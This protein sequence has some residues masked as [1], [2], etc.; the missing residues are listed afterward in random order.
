M[1]VLVVVDGVGDLLAG[2]GQGLVDLPGGRSDGGRPDGGAGG[3][4]GG[5]DG[6]GVGG[7]VGAEGALPLFP[8][9]GA[10]VLPGGQGL[11][12]PGRSPADADV[13]VL[14]DGVGELGEPPVRDPA[15]ATRLQAGREARRP[16]P[17]SP[18]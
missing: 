1:P 3:Q 7:L 8:V 13:A 4:D 17:G 2:A 9:V 10:G 14:P 6:T 5:R 16:G 18:R 12:D 11:A 15:T